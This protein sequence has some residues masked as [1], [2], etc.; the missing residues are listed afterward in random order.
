MVMMGGIEMSGTLFIGFWWGTWIVTTFLL[1]KQ[2]KIRFPLALLSIILIILYP[3]KIQLSPLTIQLPALIFLIIGYVY[4]ARLSLLKKLFMMIAIIMMVSGY[5]GFLLMTLYDPVWVIIDHHIMLALM[6]FM[7]AQILFPQNLY[8]HLACSIVGSIQ[9]EVVYGV[10]LSK[11]GFPYTAC[12]GDYLDTC[13]I[14]LS[15]TLAWFFIQ[16]ISSNLSVKN[17]IEKEKHG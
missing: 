4:I 13:A 8:S 10:I 11:W 14:Y 16:N 9:G 6:T 17:P 3:Y 1:N 7:I 2:N 15:V 12:S 5:T